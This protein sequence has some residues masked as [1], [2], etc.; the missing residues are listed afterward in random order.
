MYEIIRLK[1]LSIGYSDKRQG[2]KFIAR[3]I[4]ASIHG[5]EVTCLL[6]TNGAGKSTLLRTLAGFLPPL[7]GDIL[8]MGKSMKKYSGYEKAFAIGVVLTERPELHHITVNEL[9]GMGRS[10]HTGFWGRLSKKDQDIVNESLRLVGMENMAERMADTL[11]DGEL[12][13]A[14]IAKALAQQTLV[15]YLDEPTAFL[16]YPSKVETMLLLRYL[17]YETGRTIFLSTHD[18]E[19]ALQMADTLWLM[20]PA[21]KTPVDKPTKPCEPDSSPKESG[22]LIIGS[23]RELADK[24]ILEKF[25]TGKGFTF[26]K[27]EMRFRI[28]ELQE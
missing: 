28:Q 25:F 5:A 22:S 21:D 4:E 10:P 26:D 17:A 1:N 2:K 15:I 19:L 14:M 9:V 20:Q 24:G 11:S 27:K 16:D 7:E 6:G 8:L 23:P 18:V 12:Q 3:N 13:K